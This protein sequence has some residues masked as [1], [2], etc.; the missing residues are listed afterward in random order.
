MH[1]PANLIVVHG[2][3]PYNERREEVVEMKQIQELVVLY[4]FTDTA[5]REC[6]EAV[7]RQLKIKCK[8][9]GAEAAG[10]KVGFLVGLKGFTS[11]EKEPEGVP[12]A[13]ELLIFQGFA[14]KRMEK[15]LTAFAAAGLEK[16]RYKAIVTP[17]NMF[18][19]LHR[20]GDKMQKEHGAQQ[21]V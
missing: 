21:E 18:W 8:A 12:F 14:Y 1:F 4:H 15:V 2:L 7:L 3:M 19:S 6:I 5:R 9:V 17:H 10:Q 13:E 20:L 16:V 11:T